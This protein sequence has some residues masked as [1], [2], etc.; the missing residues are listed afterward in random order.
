MKA[1]LARKIL[2]AGDHL[3]QKWEIAKRRLGCPWFNIFFHLVK[4][5]RIMRR[6]G[7]LSWSTT[8]V[9]NRLFQGNA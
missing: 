5:K 7:V 8:I 4:G 6:P 1:R 9:V 2:K 3:H